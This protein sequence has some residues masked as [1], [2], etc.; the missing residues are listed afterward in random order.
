MRIANFLAS[1]QIL[2]LMQVMQRKWIS[3]PAIPDESVVGMI[4]GC[5]LF[6]FNQIEHTNFFLT[7]KIF[8]KFVESYF[9][10]K[11]I[12]S[13]PR[14]KQAKALNKR[15]NKLGVRNELN[16]YSPEQKRII[17]GYENTDSEFAKDS[18][19][20]ALLFLGSL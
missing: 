18:I 3:N 2:L 10:T 13:D 6:G 19:E 20:K 7:D 1:L 15:L 11:A 12:H 4:L 8:R 5:E 14:A 17:H 9:R 16:L